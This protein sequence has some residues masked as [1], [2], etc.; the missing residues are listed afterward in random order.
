MHFF[1]KCLLFAASAVLFACSPAQKIALNNSSIPT[2]TV[3]KYL[4]TTTSITELETEEG[5]EV[6]TE[7]ST[8]HYTSVLE[9]KLPDGSV[10]WRT[11]VTRFQMENTKGDSVTLFDSEKFNPGEDPVKVLI[12]KQLVS[13]DIRYQVAP[14][15]TISKMEGMNAM[16]DAVADS[17]DSEKKPIFKMIS[18]QFGDEYMA[19]SMKNTYAFYPGKSIRKG[20]SWKKKSAIKLFNAETLTTYQLDEI[21]AN[22]AVVSS[23]SLIKGDPEAPGE[24]KMGPAKI[25]YYLNG[26]GAGKM[27]IDISTGMVSSTEAEV[28][29]EGHLEV[30]VPFLASTKMPVTIKTKTLVKQM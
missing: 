18:K 15:G 24:L 22:D 10:Q 8:Q 3:Y 9:E 23:T 27:H 1:T 5:A 26:K 30:K 4:Q 28:T 25:Y 14:D 2:G 21:F 19:E 12:F 11:R 16:W 6:T 29:L 7:K 20:K 17:M 13:T